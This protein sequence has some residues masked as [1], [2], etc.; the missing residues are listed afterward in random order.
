VKVALLS[1]LANWTGDLLLYPLDVVST[2]LKA[3]KYQN[4]NPFTYLINSIKNEKTKLYRGIG[5]SFPATFIPSAI[6]ITIY[7]SLMNKMSRMMDSYSDRKELK[8]FFPFFIST[9][10]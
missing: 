7:D 10:A 5:L 9:F 3:N 2:R 6:Y 8:L 4:H 1:A